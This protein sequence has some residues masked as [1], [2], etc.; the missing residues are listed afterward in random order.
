MLAYSDRLINVTKQHG[1]ALFFSFLI[2]NDILRRN[3]RRV[4]LISNFRRK[5]PRRKR[6]DRNGAISIIKD[7][8]TSYTIRQK[9]YLVLETKMKS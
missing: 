8:P 1:L 2:D 5:N 3:R 6:E 7:C 9:I 4:Q